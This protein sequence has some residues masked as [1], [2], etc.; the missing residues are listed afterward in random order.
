[1]FSSGARLREPAGPMPAPASAGMPWRWQSCFIDPVPAIRGCTRGSWH[2]S[3]TLTPAGAPGAFRHHTLAGYGCTIGGELEI[4]KALGTDDERR[5]RVERAG[6]F[7]GEMSLLN[8][9]GLCTASVR[10]RI[11]TR[12]LEMTRADLDS[13]LCRQAAVAYDL[14]RVLSMRLQAADNAT[15]H[16]LHEKN[17]RLTEAYQELH[18]MQ[19]QLVEKERLERELQV[20][21]QIRESARAG[22]VHKSGGFSGWQ[23]RCGLRSGSSAS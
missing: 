14:A 17:R 15:I 8:P 1:M 22:F 5:L 9:D 18:A 3:H 10:A 13:L 21:R 23:R 2:L 6:G 11:P 16:D 20:A 12:V 7:V 19:A 4:V